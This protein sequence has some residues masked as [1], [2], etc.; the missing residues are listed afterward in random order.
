MH[1]IQTFAEEY[2]VSH[3]HLTAAF[4]IADIEYL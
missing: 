2:L 3:S 1:N 4:L